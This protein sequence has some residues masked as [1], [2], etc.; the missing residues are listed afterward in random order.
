M[1][2]LIDLIDWL[3]DWLMAWLTDWLIDW[4]IDLLID[5]LIDWLIDWLTDSVIH[6][7]IWRNHCRDGLIDWLIGWWISWLTGGEF[8]LSLH[9]VIP[10]IQ[11][12]DISFGRNFRWVK[13]QGQHGTS[14]TLK[15]FWGMTSSFLQCIGI[16]V[17]PVTAI[18]WATVAWDGYQRFLHQNFPS[19]FL[20]LHLDWAT[21]F[22]D[23]R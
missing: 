20:G 16:P 12:L 14:W 18:F 2:W 17:T 22:C 13:G 9:P 23:A 19:D 6:S 8:Y 11:Y 4:L 1:D 5:C 21:G 15:Y 7:L 3:L 10:L